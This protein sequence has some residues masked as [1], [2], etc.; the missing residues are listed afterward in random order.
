MNKF[1]SLF[2]D[3]R[4]G[5]LMDGKANLTAD[6]QPEESG[7]RCG[8]PAL[9]G[10]WLKALQGQRL[11]SEMIEEADKPILEYL[12]NIEKEINAEDGTGFTLT[13]TFTDNPFFTPNLLA[14]TYHMEGIAEGDGMLSRTEATELKWKEGK[15]VTKKTVVKKQKNVK[16][17]VV[18]KIS[19][20]VDLPSF[21][22]FFDSHVLPSPEG[23][24]EMDAEDMESLE[25]ILEADY[26]VGVAIRDKIV[27]HAVKWFTG[28]AE[29]SEYEDSDT[30]SDDDDDEDDDRPRNPRGRPNRNRPAA[31]AAQNSDSDATEPQS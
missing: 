2:Y 23:W 24:S 21:F 11:V 12:T 15:D 9:P 30:S 29:D 13:F 22:H 1:T 31:P 14:K 3:Q 28:E 6:G 4:L 5:V 25:M 17:K 20:E 18:R 27:P 26:E 10:F 19:R 16:T 7:D 8:T